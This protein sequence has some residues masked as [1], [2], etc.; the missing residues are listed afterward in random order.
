MPMTRVVVDV[1]WMPWRRLSRSDRFRT[2]CDHTMRVLGVRVVVY[3][4]GVI[5]TIEVLVRVLCDGNV[6][7]FVNFGMCVQNGWYFLYS[8]FSVWQSV[9]PSPPIKI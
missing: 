7:T 2:S 3:V 9:S 8:F 5:T 4:I 1:V 6:V